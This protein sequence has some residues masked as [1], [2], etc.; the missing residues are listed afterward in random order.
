MICWQKKFVGGCDFRF[1]IMPFSGIFVYISLRISLWCWFTFWSGFVTDH[2]LQLLLFRSVWR[3]FKVKSCV[4][5]FCWWG[6]YL[7]LK[8]CTLFLL[9]AR[10]DLFLFS[11]KF[12]FVTSWTCKVVRRLWSDKRLEPVIADM[13]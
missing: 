6:A 8:L 11:L 5:E 7:P 3:F 2:I 10:V 12:F 9:I 13:S 1:S 4:M